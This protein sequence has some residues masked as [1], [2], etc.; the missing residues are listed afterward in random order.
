M[1]A[2]A[3]RLADRVVITSD[4]PRTEDPQRILADVQAGL[5]EG[6]DH[7]VEANRALAIAAAIAELLPGIL[8]WSPVK[9]MR[10]TRFSGRRKCISTTGSNQNWPCANVCPELSSV[11]SRLH[12]LALIADV[13][14]QPLRAVQGCPVFSDT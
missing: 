6:T 7:I 13:C 14:S 2:I 11:L 9:G 4:N 1:A 12:P 8:Y 5:P 10:T 3:A